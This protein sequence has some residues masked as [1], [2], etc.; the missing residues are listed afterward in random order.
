MMD[1]SIILELNNRM[2]VMFKIV[3]QDKEA[4]EF[5]IEFNKYH[6]GWVQEILK[7][8]QDSKELTF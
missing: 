8:L 2:K 7:V 5:Q 3:L 1:F 4:M 6:I